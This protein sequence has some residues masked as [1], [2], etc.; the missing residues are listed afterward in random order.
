[1]PAALVGLVGGVIGR[2]IGERLLLEPHLVGVRARKGDEREA[3]LKHP[4][5]HHGPHRRT[6]GLLYRVPQIGGLGVAIGVLD[7]IMA[8]P[9]TKPV[10][11]QVLLEHP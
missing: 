10:F 2:K 3:A 8:Y 5:V 6:A 1:M 11:S 9:V 7:Q 4:R